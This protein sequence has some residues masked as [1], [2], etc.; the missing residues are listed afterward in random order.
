MD[1]HG[2]TETAKSELF[3]QDTAKL[4][5]NVSSNIYMNTLFQAT[6]S[7]NKACSG[8]LTGLY[9]EQP[10]VFATAGTYSITGS[11]LETS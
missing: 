10:L 4:S 9:G 2:N 1:V 7:V 3:N 11:F 5:A 8:T 6:I